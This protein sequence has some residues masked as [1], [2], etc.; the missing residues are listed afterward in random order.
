MN[1]R[2]LDVALWTCCTSRQGREKIRFEFT[3]L[4]KTLPVGALLRP[5][6]VSAIEKIDAMDAAETSGN[7]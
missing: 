5:V 1:A 6:V 3:E 7:A 2:S 4:L